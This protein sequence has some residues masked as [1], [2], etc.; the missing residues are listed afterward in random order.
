MADEGL[1]GLADDLRVLADLGRVLGGFL[2]HHPV[3]DADRGLR[4]HQIMRV[5]V[6]EE[7]VGVEGMIPLRLHHLV[8]VF[9]RRVVAQDSE[10][11][12]VLSLSAH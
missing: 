11:D 12:L 7:P 8:D 9:E 6:G 2:D 5:Q 1:D 3:V 4:S 10:L